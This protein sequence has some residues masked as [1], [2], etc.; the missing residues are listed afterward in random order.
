MYQIYQYGYIITNTDNDNTNFSTL[1]NPDWLHNMKTKT[2]NMN[3][4]WK[5]CNITISSLI[6]IEINRF[7]LKQ[8]F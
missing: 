4:I 8:I 5:I 2:V 1:T 3:K 6:A 7:N